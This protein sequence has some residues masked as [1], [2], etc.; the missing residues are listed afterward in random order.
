M[1]LTVE[2]RTELL[3]HLKTKWADVNKAFQKLTF[4]LDTPAKKKRKE[5]YE[6]LLAEIEKDIKTI[7]KSNNIII[8]NKNNTPHNTTEK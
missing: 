7:E 8:L 2:E 3:R 1:K 6:S 5:T 4:T